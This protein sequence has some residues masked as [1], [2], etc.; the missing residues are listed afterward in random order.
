MTLDFPPVPFVLAVSPL[1]HLLP[2]LTESHRPKA[3]FFFFFIP[4]LKLNIILPL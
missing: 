4:Y 3:V 2:H 1:N